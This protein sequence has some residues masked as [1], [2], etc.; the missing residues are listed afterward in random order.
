MVFVC[1]EGTETE[2]FLGKIFLSLVFL[3]FIGWY[4]LACRYIYLG[5]FDS[6]IEAARFPPIFLINECLNLDLSTSRAFL[7][8][9]DMFLF[10]GMQGL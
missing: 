1:L 9:S 2:N 6:E 7:P 8:T 5:L 3:V 10:S 4:M